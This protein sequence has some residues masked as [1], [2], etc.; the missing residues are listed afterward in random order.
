MP[1]AWH[2]R[3]NQRHLNRIDPFRSSAN[4][5]SFYIAGNPSLALTIPYHPCMV[6]SLHLVDYYGKCK[7]IYQT[8]ILW[9]YFHATTFTLSV[10]SRG[11]LMITQEI[12]TNPSSW[13]SWRHKDPQGTQDFPI[14]GCSKVT[15]LTWLSVQFVL[16]FFCC[17]FFGSSLTL[18]PQQSNQPSHSEFLN[19]V[20]E[21]NYGFHRAFWEYKT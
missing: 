19:S 6:Y 5:W 12:P 8:W 4:S 21:R 16:E 13:I 3:P 20:V 18:V 9:V 7:Q 15:G 1:S 14:F 10:L 2:V 11:S 17:Q